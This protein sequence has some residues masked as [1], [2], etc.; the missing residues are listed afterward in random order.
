MELWNLWRGY[1]ENLAQC[2][3]I[4]VAT[5]MGTSLDYTG[6]IQTVKIL[7]KLPDVFDAFLSNIQNI[8]SVDS[9]GR[10]LDQPSVG[11]PLHK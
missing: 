8:K 2:H 5:Q 11:A 4:I 9:G 1:G 6:S 3:V 10:Q 7:L